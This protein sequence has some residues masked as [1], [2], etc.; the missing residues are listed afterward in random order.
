MPD[1]TADTAPQ[2]TVMAPV[3]LQK[4]ESL[5]LM[6]L[7]ECAQQYAVFDPDRFCA[8]TGLDKSGFEKLC[9]HL[10]DLHVIDR[11]DSGSLRIASDHRDYLS[12]AYR[13]AVRQ[14]K[15]EMAE[16]TGGGGRPPKPKISFSLKQLSDDELRNARIYVRDTLKARSREGVYTV[17]AEIIEKHRCD[18]EFSKFIEIGSGET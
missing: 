14:L 3:Q 7:I 15:K 1:L 16:K 6:R 4:T 18:A 10:E 12:A 5:F 13:K 2:L 8:D 17:A 11:T 9:R